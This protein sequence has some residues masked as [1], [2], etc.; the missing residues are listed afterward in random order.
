M[1][2]PSDSEANAVNAENPDELTEDDLLRFDLMVLEPRIAFDGAGGDTGGDMASAASSGDPSSGPA[3][4]SSSSSSPSSALAAALA[5]GDAPI[6]DLDADDSSGAAATGGYSADYELGAAAISVVDS[7]IEIVTAP[8][9]LIAS[10]DVDVTSSLPGDVFAVGGTRAF[11]GAS[12]TFAG[13]DWTASV[14][15]AGVTS[16]TATAATPTGATAD[17]AET[18]LAGVTFANGANDASTIDRAVEIA[19][20]DTAGESSAAVTS[21]VSVTPNLAPVV[22]L[23]GPLAELENGYFI[24]N[25][26]AGSQG[27]VD[28][29]V[30][31]GDLLTFYN[32]AVIN[33]DGGNATLTQ[34]DIDGLN[35]GPGAQ[36]AAQ[37]VLNA[38]WSQGLDVATSGNA[39][40]EVRIGTTTYLRITTDATDP[41]GVATVS[42]LSGAQPAVGSPTTLTADPRGQWDFQEIVVDLPF[43]VVDRG[44]VQLRWTQLQAT[45][46]DDIAIDSIELRRFEDRDHSVI[47]NENAAPIALVDV[48]SFADPTDSSI[49]QFLITDNEGTLQSLDVTFSGL[50]AGDAISSTGFPASITA[51]ATSFT[52]GQPLAAD[53]TGNLTLGL[54]GL[55]SVSDYQDAVRSLRFEAIS[56]D[57]VTTTRTAAFQA[58][59]GARTSNIAQTFI[60]IS[61]V[62]DRPDATGTQ[63]DPNIGVIRPQ[64]FA[65]PPVKLISDALDGIAIDDPDD[66]N[67]GIAVYA[68]T[69]VGGVWQYRNPNSTD[70]TQW[71]D[72]GTIPDGRALLLSRVTEVRWLPQSS[73]TGV[74][75]IDYFVWD[76]SQHVASG[77]SRSLQLIDN[78][79]SSSSIS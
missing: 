36:G 24:R 57:P 23:D 77:S 51:T 8:A 76:T 40:F 45:G 78:A 71:I 48:D 58:F 62:N 29:W 1:T 43:F 17:T 59:D 61:P 30:Q 46:T 69:T 38:A 79:V 54:S 39:T 44:D 52:L 28:G 34:T 65:D 12:G 31:A 10:L 27:N 41:S 14:T 2:K 35:R 25:A 63:T 26:T 74:S 60:E 56:E 7:D 72:F 50:R 20:T 70:P 9:T 19:V 16:I 5:S 42:Y 22:D 68:Q 66:T 33:P 11:D 47:Y 64:D 67:H 13:F 32:G 18:F 37:I 6:V 4:D 3:P 73:F 49:Q 53:S 55:A 15:S 21:T 75:K